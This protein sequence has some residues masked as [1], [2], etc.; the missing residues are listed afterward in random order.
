MKREATELAE[1]YEDWGSLV[2]WL[3]A[4]M[5]LWKQLHQPTGIKSD[6]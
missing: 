6:E 2:E 4:E 1:K 3:I 5:T